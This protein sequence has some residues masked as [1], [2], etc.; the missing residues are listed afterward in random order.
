MNYRRVVLRL[1]VTVRAGQGYVNDRSWVLFVNVFRGPNLH[2]LIV[3][4]V[5]HPVRCVQDALDQIVKVYTARAIAEEVNLNADGAVYGL[6]YVLRDVGCYLSLSLNI[7]LGG[8][9]A[10]VAEAGT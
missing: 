2:D 1:A 9:C 5:G 4:E 10:S 6:L 3:I 7:F 8:E